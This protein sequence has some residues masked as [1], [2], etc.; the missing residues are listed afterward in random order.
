M[1][2]FNLLEFDDHTIDGD[3]R[4]HSLDS[5]GLAMRKIAQ[6][7]E[8]IA[9]NNDYADQQIQKVEEWR[10]RKNQAHESE[11]E[12]FQTL[13]QEYHQ[14]KLAEDPKAKTISTPWGRSKSRISKAAP[15]KAD[16]KALLEW[17]KQ[18]QLDDFIKV[19]EKLQWVGLKKALRVVGDKVVDDNGEV[20]PGVTVKPETVTYSVDLEG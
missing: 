1:E 17:A 18:S 13:I 11:I 7:K 15:E 5:L 20:V 14:R 3:W 8:K 2:D 9:E 10:E 16:E 6:H 19:E 4:I 12:H